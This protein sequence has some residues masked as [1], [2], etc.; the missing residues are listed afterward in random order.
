[1]NCV[2][3][4]KELTDDQ[5]KTHKRGVK[6]GKNKEGNCFCSLGCSTAYRM[7]D[8]ACDRKEE[9]LKSPR[10]CKICL[11][12]ISYEKFVQKKTEKINRSK[13][14][15][16]INMFCSKSCAAKHNNQGKNRHATI[17][18]NI[19]SLYDLKNTSF[20]KD[21]L[22]DLGLNQC[23]ICGWNKCSIEIHHIKGR[24][25]EDPHNHSNL[26]IVCPNCHDEIE[27]GLVPEK[28]IVLMSKSVPTNWKDYIPDK[29]KKRNKNTI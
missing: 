1:M 25:I 28:D 26:T 19:N 14:L 13:T 16:E 20:F 10:S 21:I 22:K 27:A 15:E 7:K 11:A 12:D 18:K 24:K 9:Y 2:F 23:S 8:E 29:Y 4:S 3:C 17:A 5:E 6:R